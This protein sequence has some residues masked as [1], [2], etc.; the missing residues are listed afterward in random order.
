VLVV[1]HNYLLVDSIIFRMAAHPPYRK[2]LATKLHDDAITESETD[3]NKVRILPYD[4]VAPTR[5]LK[6]FRMQPNSRK[7]NGKMPVIDLKTASPKFDKSLEALPILEAI[8]VK[9]LQEKHLIP[10]VA[11]NAG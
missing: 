5:Y 11:E 7:A 6:L 1:E 3:T 2:S 4:G 9:G 10:E 8:I